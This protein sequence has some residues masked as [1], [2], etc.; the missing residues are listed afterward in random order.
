MVLPGRHDRP[1]RRPS[2][3]YPSRPGPITR[4]T[5][6]LGS[7]PSSTAP[8]R[9][10]GGRGT[11]PRRGRRQH[12][13]GRPPAAVQ[14]GLDAVGPA[15]ERRP[16]AVPPRLREGVGGGGRVPSSAGG[17]AAPRVGAGRRGRRK[18]SS[19]IGT[20]LPPRPTGPT[21]PAATAGGRWRAS[22][23]CGHEALCASHASAH[24]GRPSIA[25]ASPAPDRGPSGPARTDFPRAARAWF[26]RC[27]VEGGAE[28]GRRLPGP[29][30]P[31]SPPDS[32]GMPGRPGMPPAT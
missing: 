24:S 23:A 13:P 12:A 11:A 14:R 1:S 26:H 20:S 17:S 29:G 3:P 30:P 9:H 8:P 2:R 27:P 21:S 4:T 25:P 5:G 15:A 19:A 16:A 22:S 7:A 18:P 31:R 32:G 28:G 10:T 6:F